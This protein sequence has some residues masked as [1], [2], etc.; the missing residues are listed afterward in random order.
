MDLLERNRNGTAKDFEMTAYTNKWNVTTKNPVPNIEDY[1]D[2]LLY[3]FH[4]AGLLLR[5][6]EVAQAFTK[7]RNDIRL[8]S[9]FMDELTPL[10][11]PFG[12]K[13]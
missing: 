6:E 8:I 10:F 11:P 12:K 2:L 4:L 3:E 5:S 7:A 1:D 9:P 13:E